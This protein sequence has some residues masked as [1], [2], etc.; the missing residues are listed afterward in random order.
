M[1]V[2]GKGMKH[3]RNTTAEMMASIVTV[4]QDRLN[5]MAVRLESRGV[6]IKTVLRNGAAWEE[7]NDAA[8]AEG[9]QLIVMGTHGRRGLSRAMMGS[10]AERV[11]RT[12][13]LPV[14]IVPHEQPG[15]TG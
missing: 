15:T 2:I 12:A 4:A 8:M 14:L 1:D 5:A 7:I 11:I 9:A 13:T 6:P 3:R 10:V